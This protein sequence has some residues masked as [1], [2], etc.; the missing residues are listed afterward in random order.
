MH[1]RLRLSATGGVLA[2]VGALACTSAG[3]SAPEITVQRAETR[4]Q[5]ARAQAEREVVAQAEADDRAAARSVAETAIATRLATQIEE[6]LAAAEQA[7][8]EQAAAE[9]AAAEQAAAEQEAADLAAEQAAV[10]Q[11]AAEQAAADQAAAAAAEPPS[12]PA[13]SPPPPAAPAAVPACV[14]DSTYA[15][16]PFYTSPPA[17]EGDGSNGNLPASAMT[18][19]TWGFDTVGTPQ[20]LTHRAAGALDRLHAAYRTAFGEDLHLDLTY[21]SYDEQ[22]RMREALGTIAAAPGTSTHGTGRALDLP[23]WSC[24]GFGSARYLWLV[25]N[26]PSYGWVAPSWARQNGSNPEYWHLEYTG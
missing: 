12:R 14:N 8:A 6:D 11:E 1:W 21:R 5:H 17:A 24:Y 25:E 26:G 10:E 15:G 4:A 23:E 7:A 16:P 18:R 13:A 20:Y 22:V 9:Q 19:L 2:L 3:A